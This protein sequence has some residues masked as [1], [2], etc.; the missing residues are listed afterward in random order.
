MANIPKGKKQITITLP[1]DVIEV[2]DAIAVSNYYK[3]SEQI[4]RIIIEYVKEFKK[5][6]SE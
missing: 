4:S 3:R 6:E 5:E 2:I 1:D